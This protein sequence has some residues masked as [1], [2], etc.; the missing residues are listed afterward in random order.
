ML[1]QD[2]TITPLPF[3]H[4]LSE[5]LAPYYTDSTLIFTSNRKTSVVKNYFDLDKKQLYRLYEVK[6]LPDGSWSKPQLL[7]EQINNILNNGPVCFSVDKN[8]IFLT[9]NHYDS[10]KRSRNSSNGNGIGIYLSEKNSRGEWSR[11][12]SLPFNSRRDYNTGHPTLS[13]DGNTLFFV[14]DMDNGYGK[15]DLF[16][17]KR[18][19]GEWGQPVNLGQPINTPESEVYPYYH[20]S[21]RLYFA[22]NGHMGEGG[23]DIF[24]TMET[25]EG[26]MEPVNIGPP[27]NSPADDYAFTMEP[28]QDWSFF[29]STRDGNE[30]IYKAEADYPTFSNIIPQKELKYCGSLFE[31]K[32][33]GKDTTRFTFHWDMGDGSTREGFK[34]YHCF[35][36]PG[37]YK[38]TL[39]VSDRQG[40]IKEDYVSTYDMDIKRRQQIYIS[41]PD[42]VKANSPIHF[43]TDLSYFGDFEPDVFYWNFGDGFK[44]KGRKVSYTFRKIGVYTV[45]CLSLIHI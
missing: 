22:S 24:Y 20:P 25:S 6:L 11:P 32:M 34:I 19:D 26:W 8:S 9:R 42:T 29:T 43:H 12:K 31:K 10:Y 33:R 36:G 28:S 3:N 18:T 45:S 1:A 4:K 15:S 16:Y 5:E 27:Y 35:P 44:T 30:N 21:G 41:C 37:Q 13:S 38:V 23:L 17:S 39:R 7:N 2:V 14:S 40:E